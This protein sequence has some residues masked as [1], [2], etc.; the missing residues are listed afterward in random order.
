LTLSSTGTFR[1]GPP[2]HIGSECLPLLAG[3]LVPVFWWLMTYVDPTEL[4][5]LDLDDNERRFLSWGIVEWGGPARC[6]EEMAVAMGFKSVK[7]L[8]DLTHDLADSIR[9]GTPLAASDWLRVLMATEIVFSSDTIGSGRDWR[10][11]S[12][13]SDEESLILLRSIQWKLKGI[14]SLLGIAFGSPYRP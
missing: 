13:F 2:G 4:L 12:G 6:T 5:S 8:F 9:S 1:L 7:D 14:G 10:Y 3:M 11:T